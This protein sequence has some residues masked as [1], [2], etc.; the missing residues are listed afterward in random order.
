ML[1][2]IGVN[3]EEFADFR[4]CCAV[5]ERALKRSKWANDYSRRLAAEG[6]RFSDG[7]I[8]HGSLIGQFLY[9]DIKNNR[10]DIAALEA[11]GRLSEYGP[12]G[13]SLRPSPIR[14]PLKATGRPGPSQTIFPKSHEA[15]DLLC[16]GNYTELPSP[17]FYLPPVSGALYR[18]STILEQPQVFLNTVLDVVGSHALQITL[19][20]WHLRYEFFAVGF[21]VLSATVELTV[22]DWSKP[23]ARLLVQDEC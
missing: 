17:N 2:Y 16:V 3:T 6:L 18:T 21:P 11:T 12:K 20:V 8:R 7:L 22:K 9:L 4:D 14:A 5:V 1:R 23:S 15:F 13:Q 19:G 10:P